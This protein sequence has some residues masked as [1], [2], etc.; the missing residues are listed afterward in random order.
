MKIC[1]IGAGAIGGMIAVKLSLSGEDVSVIDRGS[2]LD[3]I[4]RD[5]LTLRWHDG[6]VLNAKVRACENA[7][8][9]G[10]QDLV[11]LAAKSYDLDRAVQHID[12]LLGPE[13]MV[14]TVQNGIPWW[15]FQREGGKIRRT[16][17]EL[18]RS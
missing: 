7:A 12:D 8:E 10:K 17:P 2:H 14:M 15:Y 4:K 3:A 6:A 9:A 5:G 11:V 13:T 16:N 18:A 1:V